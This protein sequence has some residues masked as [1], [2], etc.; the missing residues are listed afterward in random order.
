MRIPWLPA[1]LLSGSLTGISSAAIPVDQYQDL[2]FD[3][4]I[5]H[6]LRAGD[7]LR[8]AGRVEDASITAIQFVFESDT[9]TEHAFFFL[10]RPDGRFE[11]DLVFMADQQ[12][13]YHVHAF[14]GALGEPIPFKGTFSQ[15]V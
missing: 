8:F 6:R 11:R 7:A 9:G 4:P 12:G 2:T 15:V 13:S 1:L 10:V 14:A 3:A 5:E